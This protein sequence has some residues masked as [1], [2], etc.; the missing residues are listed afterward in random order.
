MDSGPEFFT[1]DTTEDVTIRTTLDPR[2][3]AAAEEAMAYVFESQVRAGSVAEAAIVVMSADGAV[4]GMV[5]G[6]QAGAGLFNRATQAQRQTGS[7]FKPFVY[8]AALDLGMSPLDVI[9]D[10]PMCLSTGARTTTTT[11]SR[12]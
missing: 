9:D 1:Q 10:S 4:R 8:A 6:R 2:I 3:Q 7:S 5:G 12:A 11:P